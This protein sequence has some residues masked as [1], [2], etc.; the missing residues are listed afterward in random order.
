M[1]TRKQLRRAHALHDADL[2]GLRCKPRRGVFIPALAWRAVGIMAIAAVA[3]QLFAPALVETAA[4]FPIRALPNPAVAHLEAARACARVRPILNSAGVLI[5]TSMRHR[6]TN[7]PR[8]HFAPLS[9]KAAHQMHLA[10]RSLEGEY[11]VAPTTFFGLNVL[12]WTRAFLGLI[13]VIPTQSGGS[14]PG[15]TAV[16][17]LLGRPGR[18]AV[19]QKIRN[20]F[21]VI[22]YTARHLVDATQRDRFASESIP[23]VRGAPKSNFGYPLAG[24]LCPLFLFGKNADELTWAERCLWAGTAK[25]L[26]RV[27]GPTTPPDDRAVADKAES[28]IRKRAQACI[29]RIGRDLGWDAAEISSRRSQVQAAR[30]RDG[31]DLGIQ[32]LSRRPD[33]DEPIDAEDPPISF[34]RDSSG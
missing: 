29:E 30:L 16:K 28:Y 5:G 21:D 6:C 23:C 10:W 2:L 34:S 26:M 13:G 14:S 9:D 19:L 20:G 25:V 7:E 11:Q 32:V 18:L 15:E 8:F 3:A 24:N 17:N 33:G 12:G 31:V 4:R 22:T 1:G 27:K